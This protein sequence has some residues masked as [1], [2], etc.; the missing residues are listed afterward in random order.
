M[1]VFFNVNPVQLQ[2]VFDLNHGIPYESN[3]NQICICIDPYIS[4]IIHLCI[5]THISIGLA[6]DSRKKNIFTMLL[7]PG[8]SVSLAGLKMK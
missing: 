3:L 1:N 2:C 5:Y 6:I 8:T 4:S 7:R